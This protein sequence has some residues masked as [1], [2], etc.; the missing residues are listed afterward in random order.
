MVIL[1]YNYLEKGDRMNRKRKNSKN[2]HVFGI[3]VVAVIVL[4]GVSYF[5]MKNR[6]LN[7]VESFFKDCFVSV[8]GVVSR[9]VLN[10]GAMISDFASLRDVQKENKILKSNIERVES[11]E[12]E[13]TELKQELSKLKDELNIEHVLSDY[14]YLNATVISRNVMHWYNYLT[15]DKGS[16][17]GIKEGMVVINS[18]GLIGRIENVSTFS[19]DVKLIVAN[20][21]NNKISVTITNGDHR[22][23]GLI[24]GYSYESGLLSVEGISNT[25]SVSVGDMVYTSGLG[26]VFPSGILIGKVQDITTDV[27]DL[28]KI[29]Q[30]KPSATFD[31]INYVTIL[32]RNDDK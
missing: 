29:I 1:L 25:E 27:Y 21:T 31:D 2:K 30:V 10:F 28:A 24:N 14:D 23:T 18:T 13:N 32:K 9:P 12:A 16:H 20:D 4:I 15:I 7:I 11:L 22:M 19:S 3:F 5:F 26:G 6:K 8:Q 17:N